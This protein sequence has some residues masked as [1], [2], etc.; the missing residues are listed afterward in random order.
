LS[1][2]IAGLNAQPF[3]LLVSDVLSRFGSVTIDYSNKELILG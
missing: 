2:P 1:S 3:G